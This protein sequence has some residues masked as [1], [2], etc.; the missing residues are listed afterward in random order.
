MKLTKHSFLCV[1]LLMLFSMGRVNHSVAQTRKV[2]N[3]PYIDQR[4]LHWGFHV[5][6]HLQDIE[7]DNNGFMDEAGNQ[8]FAETPNYEPGF[9]VGILG[10]MMLHKHIALRLLP[11]M[12]FGTKNVTFR[13]ALDDERQYQS[14]KS[15]YLSI[16]VNAK[17]SAE[18]FNNFRPYGVIGVSPTIDLTVKQQQQLLV[19]R[20]D[21]YIEI[22]MGCDF[23]SPW[24]KFIPEIKFCWGLLDMINHKRS[25]I[26]DPSQ[27]I[28]TNSVKSARS[29]MF[30]LTFYFE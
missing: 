5:G 27:M 8:W 7:F 6:L 22:G 15:T 18:R 29:K 10:E 30:V 17:F 23:Y 1:L 19:N 21:C 12:H 26:S 24:F 20:F 13:N 28:Y 2:M 25:D 14:I 4:R 9:T 11:T 3:R 16:P